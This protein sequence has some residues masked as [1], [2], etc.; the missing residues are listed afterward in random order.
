MHTTE[1]TPKYVKMGT[2]GNQ[3][4][5]YGIHTSKTLQRVS[6]SDHGEPVPLDEKYNR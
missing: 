6:E 4:I 1:H 2:E 5:I 3:A